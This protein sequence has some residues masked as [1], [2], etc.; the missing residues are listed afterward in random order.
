MNCYISYGDHWST[1]LSLPVGGHLRNCIAPS[2]IVH[3]GGFAVFTLSES[4][5]CPRVHFAKT[6]DVASS[7][8]YRTFLQAWNDPKEKYCQ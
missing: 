2:Y 8:V 7:D 6:L 1:D 3:I 5:R 4:F